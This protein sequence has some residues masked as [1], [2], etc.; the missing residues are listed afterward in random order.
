MLKFES[1]TEVSL[2]RDTLYRGYIDLVTKDGI[3][4]D[5][6]TSNDPMFTLSKEIVSHQLWLYALSEISNGVD[7]KKIQWRIVQ[8][9]T[10][11]LRKRPVE[12]SIEF[13]ERCVEWL[14]RREHGLTDFSMD[15][16]EDRL[17]AARKYIEETHKD[18]ERDRDRGFFQQNIDNCRSWQKTCSYMSLCCAEA[19]GSRVDHILESDYK[20][21]EPEERRKTDGVLS[22]SAARLYNSCPRKFYWNHERQVQRKEYQRSDALD[23]GSEFHEM[24]CIL[25]ESGVD[26]VQKRFDKLM[27]VATTD[28][29]TTILC[30]S[31]A[32]AMCAN[33]KWSISDERK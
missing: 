31:Y 20:R 5:Y 25:G 2:S 4:V 23:I 12:D 26:S 11:K 14:S 16:D 15:I 6:K 22:H 7:I 9:P 33:E 29:Q 13:L 18:I 17:V 28:R 10:I 8:K 3:L 21:Y 27:G 30:K 19:E 24:V 1:K 32:M